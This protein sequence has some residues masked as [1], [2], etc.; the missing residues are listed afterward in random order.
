VESLWH[1]T[2]WKSVIGPDTPIDEL[3]CDI[4]MVWEVEELA[5]EAKHASGETSE[6]LA[7]WI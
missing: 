6:V 7:L 3:P 2:E 4:E 5:A 1:D